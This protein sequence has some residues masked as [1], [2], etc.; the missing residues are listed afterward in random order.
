MSQSPCL[1]ERLKAAGYRL[2]APRLAVV[3]V[4]E[5]ERNHLN[6]AELLERGRAICPSLSR[7]TVYRTLELLT[8]LELVRPIY[9]GDVGQRYTLAGG[10]HH[11]LVCSSC[12]QVTEF[13][14][15]A[16]AALEKILGEQFNFQI[17]G[18]LLEFYGL[19]EQCRSD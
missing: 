12:G 8:D 5:R 3:Q 7:A 9:L 19:C 1:A 13:Q 11:H 2:T 16:V 15:C 6:P 18:H 17:S 14:E 10:G 4:L